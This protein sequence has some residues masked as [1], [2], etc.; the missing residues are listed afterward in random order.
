MPV[1]RPRCAGRGRTTTAP[2]DGRPRSRRAPRSPHMA[3]PRPAS[4]PTVRSNTYAQASLGGGGLRGGDSCEAG[5]PLT[6]VNPRPRAAGAHRVPVSLSVSLI[7][8]LD[9]ETSLLNWG[10]SAVCG[11]PSTSA[12]NRTLDRTPSQHGRCR[13]RVRCLSLADGPSAD[14]TMSETQQVSPPR[15]TA[16]PP[17]SE[18]VRRDVCLS[19]APPGWASA[20]CRLAAALDRPTGNAQVRRRHLGRSGVVEFAADAGLRRS[21]YRVQI[22]GSERRSQ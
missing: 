18:S 4:G 22:A 15:R 21:C 11:F 7:T 16:G 13:S 6:A 19:A 20:C 12:G 1:R 17:E 3:H 5:A 14:R 10:V 2:N 8:G 9:L